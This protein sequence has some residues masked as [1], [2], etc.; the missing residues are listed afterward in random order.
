MTATSEYTRSYK[1]GQILEY[2]F[3]PDIRPELTST[4][5]NVCKT[6]CGRTIHIQG[7]KIPYSTRD[8][9]AWFADYFYL[10]RDFDA[11][12]SFDPRI[13]NILI[14]FDVYMHLNSCMK[15]FYARVYGPVVHAQWDLNMCETT[16][17]NA[18]EPDAG[19]CM[20]ADTDRPG[21]PT[22]YFATIHLRKSRLVQTFTN[23][24][25]GG[26]P[27]P[28]YQEGLDT[29]CVD[30]FNE[31]DAAHHVTFQP[32]NAARMSP[33]VC[34]KTGFADLRFELGWNLLCCNDH[35]LGLNFQGAAPSG[36]RPNPLVLFDPIIGNGKHWELGS[37]LTAHYVWAKSADERC[38]CAF[39]LDANLTY[40]LK[41][42]EM[43]TFD[44][45]DKPNSAYMLAAKYRKND[46]TAPFEK[47]YVNGQGQG[48]A[49][50]C[51]LEPSHI[52]ALEYA[53]VAN[54]TTLNVKV[55][56]DLHADVVAM[57]SLYHPRFTV[58][59]G[60]NF[61]ARTVENIDFNDP[62]NEC[63]PRVSALCQ[64]GQRDTQWALKGDARMF[65]YQAEQK[66]YGQGGTGACPTPPA[67]PPPERNAD[68]NKPQALSATQCKPYKDANGKI[69]VADIHHG[70]NQVP[71]NFALNVDD[72]PR[73]DN[74]NLANVCHTIT[75]AGN[76]PGTTP[77]CPVTPNTP[78][79]PPP[80]FPLTIDA[81]IPLINEPYGTQTAQIQ[82]SYEPVFLSY[83]Q[84]DLVGP[85]QMSHKV[86]GHFSLICDRDQWHPY[87][88][89]GGFVEIGRNKDCRNYPNCPY[90]MVSRVDVALSQWAVWFKAGVAFE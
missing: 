28:D 49:T 62:Y 1:P 2:L 71:L 3:G 47:L 53:P 13:T 42:R 60:Y 14:D 39:H 6:E 68:V 26:T 86:F 46:G 7:S 43:R 18:L 74:P 12:I 17:L 41:A 10:P 45:R 55:N 56:N 33:Y 24:A 29:T 65:G 48:Q 5:G 81:A 59:I 15:G 16:S 37:G 82:T 38:Q 4:S 36:K 25:A 84:L 35:H 61:W 8:P 70:K 32:L 76:T 72:N 54:L 87:L 80:P 22:G 66:I 11:T 78:S 64:P 90:N 23:Y 50:V 21:Y 19:D 77:P 20:Q 30:R 9:Y 63:F 67:S 34:R 44:L 40:I 57:F 83:D 58:D 75:N 85:R 27:D 31:E 69:Y 51:G 73:V 89:A 88:G 52:F 79:P